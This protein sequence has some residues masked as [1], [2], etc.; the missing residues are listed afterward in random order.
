VTR[1]ACSVVVCTRYRAH[2]LVRCLASLVRLKHPSYELIVVDN[3]RGERDVERLAAK[4]GAGYVTESRVG[5]SRA[6]NT[7]GR[8][9]EGE[10]IAYLDDDA[11]AEPAWLS[12]HAAAFDDP[13]LM[14]TTGRIVP[15]SLDAPAAR[16]YAAAGGID[17]GVVPFRV[18][19]SNPRWFEMANFGGVGVG[20]NMAFRRELFE[21]GWRFRESLGP[22]AGIPGEE[23]YAFFTIIRGGHAIAYLPDA[24][25]RHDY[26]ATMA[27]LR[28]RRFRI[29]QGSAAYMLMLFVEEPEFRRE[30]LRYMWEARHGSRRTWRRGDVGELPGS[31]LQ[32]LAAACAGVP[33]CLRSFLTN[34][35]RFSTP[36]RPVPRA[37]PER[38][39]RSVPN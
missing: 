9:A 22:G 2:L 7:G 12:R 19:R 13:G 10:V 21:N 18:D 32:L 37:E 3:T 25:V 11:V 33:L 27:A 15:V 17:L 35:E 34:H 1:P 30:M 31:R 23:H 39:R 14:A 20:S 24:V 38:R 28:S 29:L 36:S 5:L 26:P 8:A 16:M 6:R 4:A